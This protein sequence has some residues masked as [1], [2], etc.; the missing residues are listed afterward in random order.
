MIQFDVNK[1]SPLSG[2]VIGEDNVLLNVADF[3]RKQ[4]ISI[5]RGLYP[6]AEPFGS[7]GERLVEVA[8]TNYPVWPNG[9][10]K[11]PPSAGVQMSIQSTSANDDAAGTH[12]RELELHYLDGNLD[13]AT[14]TILLSGTTAVLTTATDIRWIQ[15]MHAHDVGANAFADGDITA[16][17]SG[18]TYSQIAATDT[19]CSSSFRRVPA[20]KQLFIDGAVASSSSATADARS[21]VR[22]V[23]SELD[24]NQYIDPLILIP[25]ATVSVQNGAIAANFPGLGPFSEGSIV[26]ATQTTNKAAKVSASWF[27]RIENA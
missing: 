26:G 11:I 27:G 13:P 2:N 18:D 7:F 5:S 23:A 25:F 16:T 17:Y 22:L 1:R 15:C 20:G 19:R 9:E 10:I 14:E 8:E 21:T 3:L 6:G 24:T 4:P 12:I